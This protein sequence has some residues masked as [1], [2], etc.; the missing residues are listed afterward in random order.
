VYGRVSWVDH[1]I[2]VF[3]RWSA[4][5]VV[6]E[7]TVLVLV[8]VLVLVFRGRGRGCGRLHRGRLKTHLWSSAGGF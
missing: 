6:V 7:Q 4:V 8:L 5:G 2:S 3:R 1:Q